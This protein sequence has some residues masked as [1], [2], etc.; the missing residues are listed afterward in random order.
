MRKRTNFFEA[1]RKR[2]RK[3]KNFRDHEEE[4]RKNF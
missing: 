2:M 1:M 4:E 3:R